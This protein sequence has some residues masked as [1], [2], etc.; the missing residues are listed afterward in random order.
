MAS[1][2]AHDLSRVEMAVLATLVSKERYGFDIQIA[3]MH[4]AMAQSAL[5]ADIARHNGELLRR[6]QTL[7]PSTG[8]IT[9]V[10]GNFEVLSR[11]NVL[12]RTVVIPMERSTSVKKDPAL[13]T[14]QM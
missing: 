13:T 3:A 9:V 12:R 4:S 5:A 1:Q 7:Q 8:I 2:K 14:Q 10:P 11:G 6:N